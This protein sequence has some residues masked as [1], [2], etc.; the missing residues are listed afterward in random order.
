ML[1][2]ELRRFAMKHQCHRSTKDFGMPEFDDQHDITWASKV[3]TGH[4]F[5]F[6]HRKSGY[7]TC[8]ACGLI[9]GKACPDPV[10]SI[11]VDNNRIVDDPEKGHFCVNAALQH[12]EDGFLSDDAKS[13]VAVVR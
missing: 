5:R 10:P 3:I 4:T 1:V 9:K 6:R 7:Y 8:R 13:C 12:F 11:R 2:T